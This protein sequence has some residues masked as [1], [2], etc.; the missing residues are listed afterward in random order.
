MGAARRSEEE[1]IMDQHFTPVRN[2]AMLDRLVE[3]SHQEPVVL[4]KHD[5]FCPISAAAYR[6]LEQLPEPVSLID[7][8]HEAHISAEVTTRT[9][10]Q[11]ESPQ[12]IV[13]NQ[14][15]A[16]WSAALY[17]ITRDAVEAALQQR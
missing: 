17:E 12:V 8:E 13:L 7:V 4:F 1:E 2:M 5:P 16:D 6:E 14:G 11:H 9:G 3:Q 10:L 15:R